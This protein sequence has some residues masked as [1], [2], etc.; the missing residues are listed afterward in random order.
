MARIGKTKPIL[1]TGH[2]SWI[3]WITVKLR[4]TGYAVPFRKVWGSFFLIERPVEVFHCMAM[5]QLLSSRCQSATNKAIILFCVVEQLTQPQVSS[6]NVWMSADAWKGFTEESA[7]SIWINS[8][9]I[10]ISSELIMLRDEPLQLANRICSVRWM[11][12]QEVIKSVCD[13]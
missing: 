8:R 1:V 5:H 3:T 12:I 4:P 11:D 6:P 2:G 10:D 7:D 9:T 13:F